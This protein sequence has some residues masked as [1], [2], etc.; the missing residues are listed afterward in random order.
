M[1]FSDHLWSYLINPGIYPGDAGRMATVL[2]PF[3]PARGRWRRYI[4]DRQSASVW[5]GRKPSNLPRFGPTCV[6]MEDVREAIEAID[7]EAGMPK[8]MRRMDKPN[9]YLNEAIFRAEMLVAQGVILREVFEGRVC[10]GDELPDAETKV[11]APS[12]GRCFEGNYWWPVELC[13]Q[14]L[15]ATA[16]CATA[17]EAV[18]E[19]P[20]LDRPVGDE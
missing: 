19:W 18:K 10:H 2:K 11:P 9:A 4:P 15:P 14:T 8:A 17:P 12:S 13:G 16:L 20:E 5:V 7:A 3:A 1:K 6:V